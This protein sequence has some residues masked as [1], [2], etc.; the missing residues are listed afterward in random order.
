V[1]DNIT[2]R[3][4][5]DRFLE[6]PRILYFENAC[7]PEVFLSSADWMPRNF[8]RRIE[9]AFPIE[10]GVLRER[11]ITEVLGTCLADNAKAR[12]LQPD[13]N[14]R[15]PKP[16]PKTVS[17]RSQ[18]EFIALAQANGDHP[19]P[20]DSSGMSAKGLKVLTQPHR[21]GTA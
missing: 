21:P 18:F 6:H 3:S 10:D 2:V 14:Y 16:A 4:V 9:T 15:P 13:G 20:G 5:V 1:S 19:K 7:R 17:R 8:Y 12:H 11:L